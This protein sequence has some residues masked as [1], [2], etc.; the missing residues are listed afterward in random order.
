MQRYAP[1][2][3]GIIAHLE[4]AIVIGPIARL[5]LIPAEGHEQK[6]NVSGDSIIEAQM[7]SQHL[8][9]WVCTK[10]TCW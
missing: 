9:T 2:A 5:E 6:G 4:R 8:P 3:E 10:A 1:G 7:T